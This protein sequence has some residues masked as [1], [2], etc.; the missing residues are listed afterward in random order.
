M[1]TY[2]ITFRKTTVSTVFVSTACLKHDT[3][4]TFDSRFGKNF[5]YVHAYVRMRYFSNIVSNQSLCQ[6]EVMLEKLNKKEK[7]Y[8]ETNHFSLF[9]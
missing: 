9:N 5:A 2:A 4:D 3:D 8:E 7:L 6:V 1:H